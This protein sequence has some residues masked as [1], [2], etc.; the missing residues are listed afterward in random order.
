MRFL[1][2]IFLGICLAAG[3]R[4]EDPKPILY[5]TE[6]GKWRSDAE[7][8]SDE[9]AS[10][11]QY[12]TQPK[13]YLPLMKI[14]IPE[15]GE[16]YNVWIRVRGY[17]VCVKSIAEDKSQTELKW[18]Y[19]VPATWT[20]MSFGNFPREKLQKEILIIRGPGDDAAAGL[21][22]VILAPE[23]AFDPNSLNEEELS[24]LATP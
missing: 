1:S 11:G 15:E 20:W 14:P 3:V 18:L 22:A 12:V 4:A 9:T 8:K 21:D 7:V 2:V 17:G 13:A 23:P 10:G 6:I 24:K 19:R 5:E 16:Y